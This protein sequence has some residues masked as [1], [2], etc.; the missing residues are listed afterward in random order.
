M[1]QC[2]LGVMLLPRDENPLG[3]AI[4]DLEDL[5]MDSEMTAIVKGIVLFDQGRVGLARV[6][7]DNLLCPFP[8]WVVNYVNINNA[9]SCQL[10]L[11]RLP[12]S[13]EQG[14]D[15]GLPLGTDQIP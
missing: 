3:S 10:N 7:L 6:G 4:R 8:H 14:P 13:L 12:E 2:H 5:G 9:S 15:A 1:S 11:C